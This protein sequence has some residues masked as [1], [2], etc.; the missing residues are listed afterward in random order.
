MTQVKTL[1][2]VVQGAPDNIAQEKTQCIV[3]RT[4]SLFSDFYF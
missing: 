4:I 2:N 3:A 1:F